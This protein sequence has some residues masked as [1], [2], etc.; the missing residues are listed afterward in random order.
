M[1]INSGKARISPTS[2]TCLE[3]PALP[4][5][6]GQ[7][8]RKGRRPRPQT[9]QKH[10]G[11]RCGRQLRFARVPQKLAQGRRGPP[12]RQKLAHF[13]PRRAPLCERVPQKTKPSPLCSTMRSRT[14]AARQFGKRS[15]VALETQ[16]RKSWTAVRTQTSGRNHPG[17][18]GRRPISSTS[19]KPHRPC[20]WFLRLT[21]WITRARSCRTT[22]SAAKPCGTASRVEKKGHYGITAHSST[23]LT[24]LGRIPSSRSLTVSSRRLSE[25]HPR[26]MAI[27]NASP[28]PVPTSGHFWAATE[29]GSNSCCILVH[30]G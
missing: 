1:A 4:F 12:T 29:H 6:M 10:A 22:G 20:G 19:A 14:K 26:L 21:N 2:H 18:R 17:G 9:G 30:A 27:D 15:G 8:K 28:D 16:S 24:N 11:K 23:P 3:W 13:P 7:M 5:I 25:W